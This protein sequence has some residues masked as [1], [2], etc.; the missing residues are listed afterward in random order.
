M[1]SFKP[2][3]LKEAPRNETTKYPRPDISISFS[4]EPSM[5]SLI[6]LTEL[7]VKASLWKVEIGAK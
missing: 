7:L 5:T 4:N 6:A 2:S 1:S 3:L